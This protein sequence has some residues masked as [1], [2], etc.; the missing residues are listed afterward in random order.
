MPADSWT[1]FFPTHMEE[2]KKAGEIR[3]H[4]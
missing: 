2:Y 4:K 1:T 3:R